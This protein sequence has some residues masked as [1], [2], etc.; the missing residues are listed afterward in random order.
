MK[1]STPTQLK[2][3]I[4][5]LSKKNLKILTIKIKKYILLSNEKRRKN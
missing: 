3:W 1:P 5:K 4:K 2:S